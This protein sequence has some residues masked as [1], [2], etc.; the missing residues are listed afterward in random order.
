MRDRNTNAAFNAIERTANVIRDKS[1]SPMGDEIA[2]FLNPLFIIVEFSA[3][4]PTNTGK[5]VVDVAD[6]SLDLANLGMPLHA[7]ARVGKAAFF[8][9]TCDTSDIK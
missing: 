3:P 1:L 9:V 4:A 2:N 5:V 7:F 6:V 8:G